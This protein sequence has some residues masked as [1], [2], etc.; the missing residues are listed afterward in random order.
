MILRRNSRENSEKKLEKYQK[1]TKRLDK[2]IN[3]CYNE[4]S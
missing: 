1:I 3:I 2:K 4:E